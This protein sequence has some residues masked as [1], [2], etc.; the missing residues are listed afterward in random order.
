MSNN[1]FNNL[2]FN[3]IKPTMEEFFRFCESK[4]QISSEEL[5][6]LFDDFVASELSELT[7]P[8]KTSP[9]KKPRN[10]SAIDDKVT[11]D[12]EEFKVENMTDPKWLKKTT[13]ATL[14][15][16]CTDRGLSTSGTK[17]QLANNLVEYEKNKTDADVN[18]PNEKPSSEEPKPV[19]QEK[20]NTDIEIK[21]PKT[22]SRKKKASKDKL[23]SDYEYT[24]DN[25]FN[26]YVIDVPKRELYLVLDDNV[27][28]DDALV[29]GYVTYEDALDADDDLDD[30]LSSVTVRQLT[31]ELMTVCQKMHLK[32][33]FPDNL[34][35]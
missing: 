6:R 19:H 34:D 13:L 30:D 5:S 21:R 16:Y 27:K 1:L 23:V 35:N 29:V 28:K 18:I 22:A 33:E 7:A 10:A 17:A 15:M 12:V 31:A 14:K 8:K 11:K 26:L 9:K 24:V 4:N 32:Y 3:G 2:F 25:K 20:K